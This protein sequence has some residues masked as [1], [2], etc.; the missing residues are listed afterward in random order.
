MKSPLS[1][2]LT[3]AA[4][5]VIAA[6][7]VT[8]QNLAIVNGKPVPTGRMD[9]LIREISKSGRPVT[10]EMKTQIKEEMILREIFVQEA[11]RRGLAATPEYAGQMDLAR[12]SVL[13][14][15]LIEDQQ[16]ALA[17]SEADVKAEY[18]RFAAQSGGKEYKARHILVDKEKDALDLIARI[19]KGAKF[20]DVAKKASKDK[21]S[22]VNG[23]SLDWVNPDSLV[24][25]FSEAMVKLGKGQ[26]T[27]A[28]VKSQFGFHVIRLDDVRSQELPPLA[29]LKPQIEQQLKQQ[30]MAAFQDELRKKAKV[31]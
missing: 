20:E 27:Q 26:M 5:L 17:I 22:A 28:P 21:G 16:K 12:Q 18:D 4:L 7:G 11:E 14:K 8:A 2:R 1:A 15:A 19:K 30:K 10:D 9:N 3:V 31:E 24:K 25:E 13:I 6:T 23:G 29:D